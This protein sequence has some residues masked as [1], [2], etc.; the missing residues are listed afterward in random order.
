[1]YVCMEAVFCIDG[2]LFVLSRTCYLSGVAH[3]NFKGDYLCVESSGL[4]CPEGTFGKS[5]RAC[6]SRN[7]KV[8]L[9]VH[10]LSLNTGRFAAVTE[11]VS[12]MATALALV[13]QLLEK[14]PSWSRRQMHLPP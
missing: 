12:A 1:M 5:C 13:P 8:Y 14:E 11:R 9:V 4:C 7:G 2:N 3:G 6:K 10:A